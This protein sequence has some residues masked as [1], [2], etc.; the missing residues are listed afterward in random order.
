V[1]RT[2]AGDY[3]ESVNG[4][5]QPDLR[6]DIR[7]PDVVP[8]NLPD[9]L[10][11]FVGRQQEVADVREALAGTRLLTLTGAGGCGK[12]RL[13]L[14]VAGEMLECFPGGAWWVELA[15]LSDP[16]L[17]GPALAGALGVRP[18][19][20]QSDLD[21]AV[22]HLAD[23]RAL[24]A[25]DNC[26][27]LLDEAATLTETLLR[28]CPEVTV[29]A[30]SRAPLGV[31]GESDWRVPSLS[32]PKESAEGLGRSDAA[33]LFVERAAKVRPDFR[34]SGENA[35]ALVEVCHKLDGIPL[36]IEL[37]AGRVRLLSVEQI[38]A[39]LADRFGL[40]TGGARSALPRQR[41][42]RASVD[43][44]HE[45][46]EEP[47]RMLL[48]RL[49]VFTG[50]FTLEAAEQVCPG[51]GFER[52]QIL[53]GLA[54]L[55]EHSLVQAEERAPAVRY[56]L[57]ETV[58]EYALERLEE[59]GELETLRDRHR[60]AYLA[61]SERVEPELLTPRE[62]ESLDLLDAEAANLQAAIEWAADTEPEKAL[63]L[64]VAL[65]LWW[66]ARGLFSQSETAYRRALD[67]AE[68][69]PRAMRGRALWGRALLLAY[70]GSFEASRP[71][72]EQ[73][74]AEGELA[75]DESTMGRALDLIGLVRMWAD[76]TGARPVFERSRELA[77][78]CGDDYGFVHAT[79]TLA[80]GYLFQDEYEQ[81]RA[82]FE[83]AAT[84]DER[85]HIGEALAFRWLGLEI[86]QY[87]TGEYH[88]CRE[89]AGRALVAARAIGDPD[90]EGL[91][92]AW[93][94]L[95]D[96]ETGQA[97]RGLERLGPARERALALGA[98]MAMPWTE[99][100]IAQSQATLG[101][102]EE[103]RAGFQALIELWAFA[104]HAVVWAETGLAEVV[105]LQGDADGAAAHAERAVEVAERIGNWFYRA[106]AVQVLGRLAAGRSDWGEAEQLHHE[107]LAMITERGFQGE[108]PNSLEAL[109]EV[110]A[111]LESNEE[112]ASVLAAAGRARRE[113][114]LVAWEG[115][116]EELAV[117]TE[118]VREA[119][120][121]EAFDTAWARGAD[122]SPDEVVGWV[123][124]ARGSRKRPSGGWESLTPTELEVVRHAA[125]GHTNPEIGERM[126]ISRGTVKT[127]LS[128]VY[129]KLE[130]R[131]R[132]ELAA[133]AMRRLDAE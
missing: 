45:L 4:G 33:R 42:L 61:L 80:Y 30:T 107:A 7:P 117:L 40:L 86:I 94:A 116:R 91:S 56:R 122:L 88:S 1:S 78:R 35:P 83:Q 19:G 17:V 60:D 9:A 18:L 11:S 82:L 25:L 98:G 133:V 16:E 114:G 121:A 104:A 74:L 48:R 46:L 62:V 14:K 84:V 63:R 92:I 127:H 8:N 103:A 66:R 5:S 41:T 128:H 67:A 54:S 119:L 52:A 90:T 53:D 43:W 44:S 109:A 12:T 77:R 27:H 124:R 34:V 113:L 120:G 38:A 126:F 100:A 15:A 125:A 39:G 50:G 95:V 32:L 87:S 76:P 71:I 29:L 108:L 10:S 85:V 23:R 36:A 31:P 118:R 65:T 96:A 123:R 112:A 13:A 26:E 70:S 75:G 69:A 21:A 130:V 64:C 68:P 59:A 72:A 79:Q 101:R 105:R 28:G 110:A 2:T 22:A 57:L 111:G 129:A 102:L 132:S 3:R 99:A 51:D 24:V 49:S 115:Q 73:A 55:V 106:R 20:G 37:A 47:Q 58:R 93:S 131:N 89:L 97:R 6:E 81:A